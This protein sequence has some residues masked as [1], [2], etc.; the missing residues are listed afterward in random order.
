V[1]GLH[2]LVGRQ[3]RLTGYGLEALGIETA[4]TVEIS[5]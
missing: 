5:L 3:A 1:L 2:G 4:R